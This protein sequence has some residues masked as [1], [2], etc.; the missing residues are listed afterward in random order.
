MPIKVLDVRPIPFAEIPDHDDRGL[1]TA[2]EENISRTA[3][4]ARF[5]LVLVPLAELDDLYTKNERDF[6]SDG[7]ME[8]YRQV[9]T[10]IRLYRAG[11]HVPPVVL[12]RAKPDGFICL[13]GCHRL[14]AQY[15]VRR[16]TVIAYLALI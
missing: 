2:V 1:R 13:D 8:G 16:K 3:S 14:T 4:A 11:A 15:L 12:M 6:L 10:L 5:L 7:D 9:R